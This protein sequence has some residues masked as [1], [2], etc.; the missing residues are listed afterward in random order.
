M[1]AGHSQRIAIRANGSHRL[2]HECSLHER[3]CG[4]SAPQSASDRITASALRRR[5][6]RH[7]P[8]AQAESQMPDPAGRVSAKLKLQLQCRF[9][10]GANSCTGMTS[11]RTSGIDAPPRQQ[12]RSASVSFGP[13]TDSGLALHPLSAPTSRP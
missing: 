3:L 10:K 11:L 1:G 4:H 5:L 6:E 8:N 9:Q 13:S 2:L 7:A 12:T